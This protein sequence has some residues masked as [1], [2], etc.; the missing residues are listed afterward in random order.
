MR[1]KRLWIQKYRKYYDQEIIFDE[2]PN[3]LRFQKEIFGNMNVILFS[4]ENGT[5]K[6]TI[7]S[8][9]SYTKTSHT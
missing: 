1:V 2:S 7:L 6:T 8:F 5:G 3:N 9:I 4:G